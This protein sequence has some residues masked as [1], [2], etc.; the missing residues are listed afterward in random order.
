LPDAASL[1]PSVSDYF[2]S[3]TTYPKTLNHT[4]VK[5]IVDKVPWDVLHSCQRY[6]IPPSGIPPEPGPK[7]VDMQRSGSPFP[8]S[9]RITVKVV[10]DNCTG[11]RICEQICSLEHAGAI[12]PYKASLVIDKDYD[13]LAHVP[14]ICRQCNKARC[15]SACR[16]SALSQDAVT[17]VIS[18]EQQ[19]CDGCEDCVRACPFDAIWYRRELNKLFVCDQCG[20][21][22]LCARYCATGAL[23]AVG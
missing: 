1:A 12:N 21:R 18:V 4:F 15:V 13:H 10:K 20:G 14:R 23:Q 6:R 5:G 17:R 7:E 16:P 11:C 19:L 2:R 22:M 9:P 3:L 8:G